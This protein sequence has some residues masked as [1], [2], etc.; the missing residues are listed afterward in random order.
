SDLT[1]TEATYEKVTLVWSPVVDAT[2]YALDKDG[3]NIYTGTDLTFTDL[4]P[5]PGDTHVYT[6]APLNDTVRGSEVSVSV[7]I[8]LGTPEVTDPS[9][10]GFKAV[11]VDKKS[12]TLSW[13]EIDGAES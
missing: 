9:I 10:V 1:V 7:K 13:G 5:T 11:T 2:A 3:S 4:N 8:P 12:I 6:L